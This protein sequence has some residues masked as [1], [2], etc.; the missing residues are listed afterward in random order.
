MAKWKKRENMSNINGMFV[1][2]KTPKG[3]FLFDVKILSR[4]EEDVKIWLQLLGK[5]NCFL[6]LFPGLAEAESQ[7]LDLQGSWK[8][9][10]CV[11]PPCLSFIHASPFSLVKVSSDDFRK[12]KKVLKTSLELGLGPVGRNVMS[13][14]GHMERAWILIGGA[15]GRVTTAILLACLYASWYQC[16]RVPVNSQMGS[17]EW[18]QVGNG[19]SWMRFTLSGSAQGNSSNQ[20]VSCL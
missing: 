18:I 9:F 12:K 2:N 7:M 1:V 14:T 5:G 4:S 13:Y 19:T 15:G 10:M 6:K 16:P 8:L 3:V 11:S 17:S 20:T